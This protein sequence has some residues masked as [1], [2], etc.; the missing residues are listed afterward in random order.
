MS[1][2]VQLDPETAKALRKDGRKRG[3][4]AGLEKH[5]RATGVKLVPMHPESDDPE[6]STWFHAT[7]PANSDVEEISR[8]LRAH[9][10]VLAAYPKPPTELP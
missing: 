6:L 9:S 4:S 7:V 8:G 1:L 3:A 5:L 10:P 2:V